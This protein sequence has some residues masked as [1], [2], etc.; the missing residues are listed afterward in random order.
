MIPAG[1][2]WRLLGVLGIAAAS[3]WAGHQWAAGRAA[4]AELA[5][6]DNQAELQRLQ[7]RAMDATATRHAQSLTTINRQLEA[8]RARISQLSGRDCLDPRTVGLLN[9]IAGGV[10]APASEPASA[11]AAAPAG[12]GDWD[13]GAGTRYSTDRDLA[14]AIAVCRAR[15]AEVSAQLNAVL[16][17]ED[18]RHPPAAE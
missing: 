10:R 12:G 16:D 15:Y 7:R 5:S 6:Q 1:I 9:D 14:N 18:Q 8:A 11:P 13:F 4:Q 3:F 2:P 17:I